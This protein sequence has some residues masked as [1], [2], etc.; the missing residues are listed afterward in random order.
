MKNTENLQMKLHLKP[1][2]FAPQTVILFSTLQIALA[3]D[4]VFFFANLKPPKANN[5]CFVK[6][7]DEW[8]RIT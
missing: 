4:L 6:M 1:P 3:S 7:S 2:D 5:F 8:I